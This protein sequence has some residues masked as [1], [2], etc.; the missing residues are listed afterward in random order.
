M[1]RADAG[2]FESRR[3]ERRAVGGDEVC[4]VSDPRCAASSHRFL[5]RWL[6]L[7]LMARVG[8][9]RCEAGAR[10]RAVQAREGR[11]G[12]GAVHA[13]EKTPHRG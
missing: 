3:V 7:V 2:A 1:S 8:G 6:V 13:R 12:L 11:G 4:A 9:A 5:A 10:G